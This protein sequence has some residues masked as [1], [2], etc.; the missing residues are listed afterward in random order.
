MFY[1]LISSVCNL[2]DRVLVYSGIVWSIHVPGIGFEIV[3]EAAIVDTFILQ[4]V[5]REG[6]KDLTQIYGI[7]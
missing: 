1:P 2:V 7:K 4:E 5:R 6:C 3:F